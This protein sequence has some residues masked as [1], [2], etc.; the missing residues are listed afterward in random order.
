MK[1]IER[2]RRREAVTQLRQLDERG[3]NRGST[4]NLSMR[5]EGGFLITPTGMGADGLRPEDLVWMDAQGDTCVGLWEPSSEWPFHAAIYK[6]RP[7]VQCVVHT[8]SVHATAYSC[9][10]RELPAFH[11]MV[12]VAGGD[13]VPCTP[14]HTF[15]TE[16]LSLAVAGA[17]R[18][19]NACLLANHGLVAVGESGATATRIAIEIEALCEMYLKLLATGQPV[20]LLDAQQ[21]AEVIDKFSRYGKMA[22]SQESPRPTQARKPRLA[23]G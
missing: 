2:T 19:R 1:A 5:F 7:E 8:H 15:G 10:R 11:Y 12:A 3:L 23:A 4:G 6:I 9:L 17:L 14:Y 22:R 13:S 21:M 20:H 16:V 18:E